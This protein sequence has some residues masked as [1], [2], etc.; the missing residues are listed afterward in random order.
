M[1]GHAFLGT[2]MAIA[3]MPQLITKI[4]LVNHP[5]W[6]TF[7]GTPTLSHFMDDGTLM[8]VPLCPKLPLH[9]EVAWV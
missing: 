4:H 7:G 8:E 2:G 5:D 1:V 9:V 3:I 6:L